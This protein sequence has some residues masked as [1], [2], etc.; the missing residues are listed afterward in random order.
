M[1]IFLRISLHDLTCANESELM[2]Q[3]CKGPN[4]LGRAPAGE[5]MPQKYRL[6]KQQV[7][8][9]RSKLREKAEIILVLDQQAKDSNKSV[10]QLSTELQLYQQKMQARMAEL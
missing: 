2:C 4:G 10:L 9:Y 6:L 8:G 5:Q 1:H 3:E 7:K